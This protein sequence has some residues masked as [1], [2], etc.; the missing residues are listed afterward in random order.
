MIISHNLA[1]MVDVRRS[2]NAV[3]AGTSTQNGTGIDMRGYDG[4]LFIA[5][6]G[7][8]TATQTTSLKAQQ[9]DDDGGTDTYDDLAGSSSGNL[10]DGDSNKLLV[11]DI[12][13]PQKRYVRPVVVRGTA[14]AVIDFVLAI[15]YRG[16]VM[17]ALLHSTVAKA[18]KVL[19]SP[20]EGAA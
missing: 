8:L 9:S 3:A 10:A 12:Y 5:G 16:Q 15:P 7:T 4:V 1:R 11:L 6:V 2:L 14:N 20:A 18:F 13:R 17:P 19:S